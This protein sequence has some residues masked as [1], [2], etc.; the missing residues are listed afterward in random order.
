MEYLIAIKDKSDM[1]NRWIEFL[2]KMDRGLANRV[3][4]WWSCWW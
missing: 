3:L 2:E 4:P 1:N